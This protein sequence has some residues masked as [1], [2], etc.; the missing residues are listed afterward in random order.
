MRAMTEEQIESFHR[1]AWNDAIEIHGDR[2]SVPREIANGISERCRGEWIVKGWDRNG[3]LKKHL[4]SYMI[5]EATMILLLDAYAPNEFVALS[6]GEEAILAKP[7]KKRDRQMADLVRW[8]EE[9]PYEI[10]TVARLCEVGEMAHMT[11]R[12]FINDRID[13][14]KK[15]EKR[16][17]FEIR[18]VREERASAKGGK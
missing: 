6:N 2:F 12:K 7:R 15:S 11:I 8:C 13:L 18:N 4:C 5:S 1:Q 17:E 14:F 10:V 16:G 3:S 9:H